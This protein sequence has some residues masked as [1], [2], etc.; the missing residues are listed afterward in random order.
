MAT[1]R[2]KLGTMENAPDWYGKSLDELD[3]EWSTE[4][5]LELERYC[6]KIIKNAEEEEMTPLQRYDATW[7]GK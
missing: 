7:A 6:E 5:E 4:E 1:P 2:L 3:F